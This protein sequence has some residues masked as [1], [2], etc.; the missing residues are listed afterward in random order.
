[1]SHFMN[2]HN[3]PFQKI[4]CGSKTIE[5]RLYDD[6]RKA[7]NVGDTIL[8]TNAATNEQLLVEVVN[9]QTFATFDELYQQFDKVSIGYNECDN[10]DPK[11]ML[12][13]YTAE[14]IAKYGALAITFKLC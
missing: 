2:L 1:M 4:K 8:F 9:L 14:Q 13:Y 10:A 11:D 12:A 7:I 6:K 3:S 5:M